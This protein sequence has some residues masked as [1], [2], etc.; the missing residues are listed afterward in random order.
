MS[1]DNQE[2]AS[3]RSAERAKLAAIAIVGVAVAAAVFYQT[4]PALNGGHRNGENEWH[5]APPFPYT[6]LSDFRTSRLAYVYLDR[7]IVVLQIPSKRPQKMSE[8]VASVEQSAT[9]PLAIENDTLYV[10][11]ADG[12]VFPMAAPPGLAKRFQDTATAAKYDETFDLVDNLLTA[13]RDTQTSRK[14]IDLLD[15]H[16]ERRR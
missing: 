9:H 5:T 8:F 6:V 2:R 1:V 15:Q 13:C 12:G 4:I 3:P 10:V 16:G 14:L 7:N 11:F